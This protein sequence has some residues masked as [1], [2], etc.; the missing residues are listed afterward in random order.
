MAADIMIEAMK[1]ADDPTTGEGIKK[2]AESIKDFT[3]HQMIP[4]TTL[5]PEDHGGTRQ[6]RMYQVQNGELRRIKDW[7]EGPRPQVVQ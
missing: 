5:T 4:G 2:G 6:V 7:F 1:L 3:A